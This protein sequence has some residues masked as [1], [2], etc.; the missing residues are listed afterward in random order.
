[1]G[2]SGH[3][4][5]EVLSLRAHFGWNSHLSP[6]NGKK[7]WELRANVA[8]ECEHERIQVSQDSN[9]YMKAKIL[10][11]HGIQESAKAVWV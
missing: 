3:H 6:E 11:S 1:M 4:S 2:D 7:C 10:L 5:Q 8:T 9:N